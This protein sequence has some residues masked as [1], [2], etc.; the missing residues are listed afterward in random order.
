MIHIGCSGWSYDEWKGVFYPK[1][2][3]D[4]LT[5]YSSRFNTT[6]INSSFYSV[7]SEQMVESWIYKVKNRKNFL[8]SVKI[9]GEL[10]HDLIMRDSAKSASYLDAFI[11][12]TLFPLKKSNRL[13]CTLLQLPPFFRLKHLETMVDTFHQLDYTGYRIFVEFRN[14]DFYGN[15]VIR[16][17]LEKLDLGVVDLDG[18][19]LSLSNIDS[20]LDTA[21]LRLHGH[22]V[23]EWRNPNAGKAERYDY[24]YS[25]EEMGIIAET[26]GRRMKEY[27]D[28]YIYFN[29]HPS[30]KAVR[31]AIDLIGL[32]DQTDSADQGKLY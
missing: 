4:K 28:I 20:S 26:I 16:T 21:Y 25:K 27:S 23:T 29:N 17:M 7:P 32:L 8:F 9:P 22:N 10:S 15:S 5:Y 6:E 11:S 30:G 14:H 19:D 12:G 13:G 24:L 31:N 2:N 1:G 18:P 3:A